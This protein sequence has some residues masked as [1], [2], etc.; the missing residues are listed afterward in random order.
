MN[1]EKPITI[2]NKKFNS[3]ASVMIKRQLVGV[4]LAAHSFIDKWLYRIVVNANDCSYRVINLTVKQEEE[5][6]HK[7]DLQNLL[8]HTDSVTV[9]ETFEE[10]LQEFGN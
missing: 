1:N 4:V 6:L 8:Y 2:P 10:Y 3:G 7:E 9:I 5:S